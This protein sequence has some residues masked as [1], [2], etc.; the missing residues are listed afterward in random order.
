M[1]GYDSWLARQHADHEERK[2]DSDYRRDLIESRAIELGTDAA[3]FL[4]W[5][6]EHDTRLVDIEVTSPSSGRTINA[7]TAIIVNAPTWLREEV[8]N[9]LD[10]NVD[11]DEIDVTIVPGR[12]LPSDVLL[13]EMAPAWLREQL[14]NW[15]SKSSMLE[16]EVDAGIKSDRLQ[17]EEDIAADRY[18]ASLA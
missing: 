17:S 9:A 13:I 14:V 12:T 7:R 1:D 3:R 16:T 6:A 8:V 15:L 11:L 10:G 2:A 18:E 5:C 4:A